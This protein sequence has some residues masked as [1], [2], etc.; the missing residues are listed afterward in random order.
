MNHRLIMLLMTYPLSIIAG[1]DIMHLTASICVI[2]SETGEAV[3]HTVYTVDDQ[4]NYTSNDLSHTQHK[5]TLKKCTIYHKA[6]YA[7]IEYDIPTGSNKPTL[8]M[9]HIMFGMQNIVKSYP[10][11]PTKYVRFSL[12]PINEAVRPRIIKQVS[13]APLPIQDDTWSIPH[14]DKHMNNNS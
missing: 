3:E 13:F 11:D 6:R 7:A 8:V 9:A 10:A 2:G 1:P 12:S 5:I 14:D 4:G